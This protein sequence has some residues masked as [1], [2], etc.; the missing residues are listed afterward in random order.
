MY[1]L[2]HVIAF[3]GAQLDRFSNIDN[4]LVF[5]QR[6]RVHG[7]RIGRFAKL[8]FPE[9]VGWG[10]VD[11]AIIVD[12]HQHPAIPNFV[13]VLGLGDRFC[14]LRDMEENEG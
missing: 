8:A 5:V 14:E 4:S 6:D 11:E 10:W 7:A 9:A 13:A 3:V 12:R 1:G 2:Q